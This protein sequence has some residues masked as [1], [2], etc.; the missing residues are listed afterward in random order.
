MS[1][2]CFDDTR[3]AKFTSPRLTVVN[4]PNESETSGFAGGF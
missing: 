1:V 2:I 4:I 3:L